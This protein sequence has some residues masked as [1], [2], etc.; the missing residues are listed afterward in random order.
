VNKG[1]IFDIRRFTV[2]DG[3]GIRTT[4]FFKGCPLSCWW[5]HNPESQ[6]IHPEDSVKTFI[7]DGK[8]FYMQETIGKWMTID[9]VMSELR[10][11]RIFFEESSGGVTFSGGEPL[12]Q[13]EFLIGLLK[14]CKINNLHTAIDTSGYANPEIIDKVHPLT[15]LFLYDLKLMD[16]NDHIRYTGVSN[17]LI[18]ENLVTLISEEKQVIIRIPIV[19]GITDTQKNISEIK[20]FLSHLTNEKGSTPSF[21]ISLLPYH[22]IGKNKYTRLQIKNKT[23]HLPDLTKESLIPLKN[24]FEMQGFEVRIGG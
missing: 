9:E 3:P 11:D 22:S 23:E 16:E 24:E 2:H 19:P 4:V 18:L 13:H 8:K 21:K 7:L 15:D 17:K 10:L 12:L 20:D 6:S 1:L 5:C 14:E